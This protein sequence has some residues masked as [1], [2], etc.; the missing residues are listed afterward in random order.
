MT[1]KQLKPRSKGALLAAPAAI[2]LILFF[3][4]PLLLLVGMS[5]LRRGANPSDVQLP[6]TLQNY[7]EIFRD[8]V[9]SI[10]LRSIRISLIATFTCFLLGYP[11]ACFIGT[12]KKVWFRQV[13]LFLVV[14]PFWSN[15][16]VR[17]YAWQLILGRRGI[18][19]EVLVSQLGFID[20]PLEILGTE[21]A[22]ILGLVYGYLPF[23]VLP[24]YAVVD[25]FNFTLV[26]AGHDLG[27]NDWDVFWEVVFPLTLP[28]VAVGWILVFI[29]SIGAFITPNLLGGTKG[30]MI[31]NYVNSQFNEAGGSWAIGSASSIAIM[32]LVSIALV[33]YIQFGPHED[34]HDKPPNKLTDL[35][36]RL[37]NVVLIPVHWITDHMRFRVGRI[38][39]PAKDVKSINRRALL[40]DLSIRWI[41]RILM[42]IVSVSGILFLWLPISL[43]IA[44]S[45]NASRRFTGRWDGFTTDWYRGVFEGVSGQ[46]SS[47]FST[48]QL[49]EAL[50]TS[51]IVGVITTIIAVILG[52]TMA[53]ALAL[54][55]FRGQ[56]VLGGLLYLPVTIP[57]ITMGVSLLV[58]FRLL[59]NTFETLTGD[60]YST[61]TWMVIIAHVAFLM[62]YVAIVVRARLTN[63]NANLEE[64]SSDLGMNPWETFRAVTYPMILPGIIAGGLLA[65]TLSLD[66]FVITFFVSGGTTTTLPV[67]V[68]S[69]IRTGISPQINVVSTLMI[70]ASAILIAISLYLQSRSIN[71]RSS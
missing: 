43:L 36:H 45:F 49:V 54:G 20:D 8:P 69:L 34:A 17:T 6:V 5:F 27:A 56:G 71:Q 61:S 52:T 1:D 30:F 35:W 29:P 21:T 28:G 67:Y 44:F 7:T 19:N 11:L 9:F 65:F 47:S 68:W 63:M 13:L 57:A 3:T 26:E 70:A 60:N 39:T 14:L 41:G 55:R 66:D 33:A 32:V 25:R 24:I 2:Y 51:L 42:W 38:D 4:I 46:D 64:A 40:R 53:L 62:S 58:L 12:R 48:T 18:L 31:G 50:R 59:I 37:I 10:L 16:L 15:F 23:M 22:V